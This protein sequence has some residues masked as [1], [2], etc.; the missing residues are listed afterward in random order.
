MHGTIFLILGLAGLLTIA[1]LLQPLAL[2]LNFPYTVLLAAAGIVL[3]IA[4][5]I[6]DDLERFWMIGDFLL[7]LEQFQITSD[8]VFFIFLPAL[9]FESALNISVRH[10]MDDIGPILLLAIIGLLISTFLIGLSLAAVTGVGLVACL[11][12]GAIVSATDP[13]A[14]ISIFKDLGAPHRLTILVE[15]ESL[16]NDATAIVLFTILAGILMGTQEPSAPQAIVSFITV[17]FGGILAGA[18]IAWI[19]ASIIG[20]IRNMPV[21]EI[22]LTV[23]LAYFSFLFAEHYLHVSGVMAVVSA[24]IVMRSFGRT[25]VSAT[26]WHAMMETWEQLAFWANSLIFFLVGLIVSELLADTGSKDIVLLGVLVAAALGARALVLYA[27]LPLMARMGIGHSV[28]SAYRTVMFWGGLR[29]AVSLALALIVV[30]NPAIDPA[31]KRLVGILVTGFVLITLFVN[32]TT[33]RALVRTLRLDRLQSSDLVMRNQA[34]AQSLQHILKDLKQAASQYRIGWAAATE[35]SAGYRQRLVELQL[36][37]AASD[38]VPRASLQRIGLTTVTNYEGELYLNR[39]AQGLVSAAITRH[40]LGH[41]DNLLDT[42]KT[43]DQAEYREAVQ[44]SLAVGASFRIAVGLH[45][46]LGWSVPLARQIANR[47]EVLTATSSV[48]EE[49]R[50]YPAT[51]LAP[52]VG[53]SICAEL[54]DL[55]EWRSQATRD[56]LDI[57]RLQYPAYAHTVQKRDLGRIALRL[58][59][60]DYNRML[61][62][63]VLSQEAYTDLM[64]DLDRR[65]RKLDRQPRLDLV[66]SAEEL[67]AR[68]PFFTDQPRDFIEG[69][70]Q[71]LQPRLIEPG[72]HILRQGE[73]P[74]AM[75]FIATGAVEVKLEPKPVRLGSGE[76]LGAIALLTGHPQKADVYALGYGQL[77]SLSA[78]EF[79]LLLASDPELRQTITRSALKSQGPWAF[80]G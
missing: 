24:G 29:G 55:L 58:E 35:V 42:L 60:V 39:F 73:R 37:L 21:T 76:F 59:E 4:V 12:L 3:G 15:G 41:I 63:R 75:Y 8:A 36:E 47:I 68:V 43:A 53:E 40:L 65:A 45:R 50:S 80:I 25:K 70:A 61:K 54:T 30:E 74:Q 20:Q 27:V 33:I 49:L 46:R 62:E 7:S 17:F 19:V 66:L 28:S 14:V 1:S 13:V 16:F 69:V 22:T 26:T 77:F 52:L 71:L 31:V 64:R 11:L 5:L 23:C 18:V 78:H 48:V 51:R 79:E 72:E 32:A 57:L 6:L 10:L 56:E 67:V 9:I 44:H 38:R 34:M 2:R